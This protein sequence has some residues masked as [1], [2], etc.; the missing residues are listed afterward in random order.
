MCA[1]AI[2]KAGGWSID[3]GPVVDQ[4][5][6]DMSRTGKGSDGRSPPLAF[7]SGFSHAGG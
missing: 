6:A 7:A 3:G 1:R 5:D 2:V 4:P